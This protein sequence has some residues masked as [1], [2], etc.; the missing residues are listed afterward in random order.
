MIIY[1]Y[2]NET[3]MYEYSK[4]AQISPRENGKF[5]Y[6]PNSTQIVPPKYSENEKPYFINNQWIIKPYFI[7]QYQVE[8][9]TKFVSVVNYEGEVKSGFQLIS[10]SDAEDIQNNPEM[11]EIKNNKLVKLSDDEYNLKNKLHDIENKLFKAT[12]DYEL[13]RD[14]PVTYKNGFT[15]KPSYAKS[16]YETL[17][18]TE[19]I[20]REINQTTFPQYIKD[21]TKLSERA[22][23]MSYEELRELAFYLGTLDGQA[24]KIKADIE[25]ELMLEHAKLENSLKELSA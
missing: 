5:I 24:W 15:Y 6:P 18:N 21:S 16:S 8:L 13:F 25:A 17:L 19:K 20:A 7:N 22:V 9:E 4:E 3:K 11:W 2:N 10:K 12:E 23:S 1:I 14:T